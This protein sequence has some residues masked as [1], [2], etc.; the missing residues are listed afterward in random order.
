ML[1]SDT[2]TSKPLH[3]SAAAFLL[4][5]CSL[6]LEKML[7]KNSLCKVL[8]GDLLILIHG[9]AV[10]EVEQTY[11]RVQELSQQLDNSIQLF[12]GQDGLVT[13]YLIRADYQT[14]AKLADQ[15]LQIGDRLGDSGLQVMARQMAGLIAFCVGDFATAQAHLT[16]A[17]LLYDAEHL[18]GLLAVATYCHDYLALTS[19][20]QGY[21]ERAVQQAHEAL[22]E[23][24]VKIKMGDLCE[25]WIWQA[26]GKPTMKKGTT[27]L[28]LR[29]ADQ[30]YRCLFQLGPFQ[31][32]QAS[33]H[34]SL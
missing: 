22:G 26:S 32:R 28:F 10:D 29:G 24:C 7:V 17:L 31:R 21:P 3:I 9:Y 19:R 30:A 27:R 33:V 16:E 18:A 8:W 2:R 5:R 1:H 25:I 20:L 6:I 15:L 11:L 12:R 34:N 4:L 23:E 13:Y 14:A